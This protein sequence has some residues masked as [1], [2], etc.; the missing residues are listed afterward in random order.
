MFI[1]DCCRYRALAGNISR[2]ILC[3]TM[4]DTFSG[5]TAPAP[6][7]LLDSH[8]NRV[9]EKDYN[10]EEVA[11]FSV[12]AAGKGTNVLGLGG[13]LWDE[14]TK[15]IEEGNHPDDLWDKLDTVVFDGII[16]S[17]GEKWKEHATYEK[18]CQF[19][20]IQSKPVREDDFGL[21]R[22]LGRGG[23]GL[24]NGCKRRA[25]GKVRYFACFAPLWNLYTPAI[26]FAHCAYLVDGRN[27]RPCTVVRHE[28]HGQEA[29]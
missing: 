29:C 24:V 18:L 1:E 4:I 11:S 12:E 5:P 9:L 16:K 28:G 26:S 7:E 15:S 17:E 22:T 3:K 19:L 21:F 6:A 27:R 14:V 25:S 8:L 13:P 10:A 2:G 20:Y 23:F